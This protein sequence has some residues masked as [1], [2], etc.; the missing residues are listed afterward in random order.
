M[1]YL[2]DTNVISELRKRSNGNPNV[3]RWA[4]SVAP[5]DLHTSVLVLSEIRR[6]IELKRRADPTQAAALDEWLT[7]VRVRLSGRILSVDER[8]ADIW[9]G[10]GV[11]DPIPAID[12]LLAATAL[13]HDLTL[14][15][16]NVSDLQRTGARL[17]NPFLAAG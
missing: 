10:L 2:L 8:V 12:G 1:T 5:Q 9:G 11:P 6:G 3:V 4:A 7:Q 13:A 14:V 15:S 16:R 17:L